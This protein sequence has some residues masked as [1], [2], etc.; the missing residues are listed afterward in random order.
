MKRFPQSRVRQAILTSGRIGL[1]GSCLWLLTLGLAG[2]LA[3]ASAQWAPWIDGPSM[4]FVPD[5]AGSV[6]RPIRGIPGAASLGAPIDIGVAFRGAVISP[7]HDYAIAVRDSDG[8]AIVVDLSSVEPAVRPLGI[9]GE[10]DLIAVSP[11]GSVVAVYNQS[12]ASVHVVEGPES[13]RVEGSVFNVSGVPGEASGLAISDDG[14]VA[15]VRFADGGRSGLWTLSATGIPRR[16]L[17]ESAGAMTFLPGRRDAVVVDDAVGTASIVIDVRRRAI[18]VPLVFAPGGVSGF[19]SV[20]ADRDGS[21]VFLADRVSGVVAIVDLD[22]RTPVWIDCSCRPMGL[23][24][25]K[26]PSIFR[27]G[28]FSDGPLA[29]LDAS[30]DPTIRIVPPDSP[31]TESQ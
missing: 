10:A 5:S 12:S 14:D 21:R 27:L 4:G 1:F 16:I 15:I 23:D 19:S 25:L 24:P 20:S 22:T 2:G 29:V 9:D 6:I 26:G 28:T 30:L 18:R 17:V 13:L 31:L 3:G 8:R 11:T 7:R